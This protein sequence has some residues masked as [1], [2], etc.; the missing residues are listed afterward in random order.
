MGGAQRVGADGGQINLADLAGFRTFAEHCAR[1]LHS[2][3]QG[4]K[5]VIRTP[6]S[7]DP[8]NLFTPDHAGLSDVQAC[9]T[10]QHCHAARRIPAHLF[11]GQFARQYTAVGQQVGHQFVGTDHPQ[12]VILENRLDHLKRPIITRCQCLFELRHQGRCAHV[13]LCRI[14]RWSV[15][16]AAQ[17]NLAD[18][19]AQKMRQKTAKRFQ[20]EG[21]IRLQPIRRATLIGADQRRHVLR[22]RHPRGQAA[23]SGDQRKAHFGVKKWRPVSAMTKLTIWRT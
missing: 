12:A 22:R 7:L 10:V 6:D 20:P 8:I 2:L 17:T 18:A 1:A 14:K 13:E 23:A 5:Q 19:H 3:R 15:D 11:V 4:C 21:Q 16:C 9:Q